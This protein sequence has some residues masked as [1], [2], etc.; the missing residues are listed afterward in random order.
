MYIYSAAQYVPLNIVF[1]NF[2]GTTVKILSVFVWI[3]SQV[4]ITKY[5]S[6]SFSHFKII[7][8]KMG[9]GKSL[10]ENEKSKIKAYSECDLSIHQ[11][12]KKTQ[13]SR[14]VISTFL[15]TLV[16]LW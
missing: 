13:R 2:I 14:K 10:A 15:R 5:C 4:V 1:V 16:Q 7:S 9:R 11:I 8:V 12:A 6:I 3:T